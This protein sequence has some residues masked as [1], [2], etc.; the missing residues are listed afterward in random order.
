ME[1]NHSN[2]KKV[3]GKCSLCH[4]TGFCNGEIC[5][6]ITRKIETKYPDMPDVLK[7]LFGEIWD[8]PKS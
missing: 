6:C 4:G 2:D 7:D 1:Q 5:T 8:E 3:Q